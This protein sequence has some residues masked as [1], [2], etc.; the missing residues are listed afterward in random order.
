MPQ[1]TQNLKRDR[2]IH[3]L[4]TIAPFSV[5]E[6]GAQLAESGAVTDCSRSGAHVHGIVRE[7]LQPSEESKIEDS[8]REVSE[9]L[10]SNDPPSDTV[11]KVELEILSAQEIEAKCTC[12]TDEEMREQWCAHAVALLLRATD[13]GFSEPSGGFAAQEAVYRMNL[14]SPEDIA[15]VISEVS[16]VE[17]APIGSTPR[18]PNVTLVID[19]SSDRLGVQVIF[20]DQVQAPALFEDTTQAS[21]RELDNILLQILEDNGSWDDATK[22]WFINS[23]RE[24][25]MVLGL[26]RE[27]DIV[28]SASTGKKLS[29]ADGLLDASLKIEWHPTGAELVVSWLLPDGTVREKAEELI[30]SGPYWVVLRQGNSGLATIYRLSPAATRISSIFPFGS[31]LTL[32]RSQIGPLLAALTTNLVDPRRIK[33]VNPELQPDTQVVA[34]RPILEVEK[35]E[36]S[37]EHF[38]SSHQVH[39]QATL[40]FEYPTP[41]EDENLVYLP[42]REKEREHTDL[43]RSMG[44]DYV[45]DRKRYVISGDSALDL[46]HEQETR[47]PEPW[48]IAGLEQVRKAYRFAQLTVNVNLSQSKDEDGGPK[49]K[50]QIDWFDCHIS[51]A[52]NN[53]N[54]P[55]STLFKNLRHDQD[56]W[57][58]LDSGAYAKIPGGSA[59]HLKSTLGMLDPNFRLSNNIR[60]RV[61]TAQ[62]I[63]FCRLED[64][65]VQLELDTTL[66]TLA[67]RLKNFSN[68]PVL[69]LS[70]KFEGE[71]RSYQQ[72]GLSWLGFL[73]EFN[74]GGILADEMGLGKTVQTLAMLQLLADDATTKPAKGKAKTS[75]VAAEKTPSLIVAP[76]SVVMNWVYE[77]RR[78][79]PN[80][81][82]LLLHGPQRRQLLETLTQYDLVVTSYALLRIDRTELERVQFNYV[83][84]DEA[85]NIKNPQA[86]TTR[87]AKAIKARHRLAL[88]GTP[89]ENRP[90]ELWSI[91]DFVMPG[92]L[93]SMDFFK[94]FIEKPIL[95]GGPSAQVARFLNSKTRPFI[96]RRMKSEVERELPA[97]IES[98]VHVVMTDS[99]R[100]LY[101]QILEDVRPRVFDA[102]KQKGVR[103]ASVSILA[104]LLRLRQVCNHP[105]SIDALKEQPGFDSGKFELLQELVTEALESGRK[106][107]L[108]SQFKEMLAIIRRWL[109][110]ISVNY[111][112]LDGA[113]RQRQEL[114][115]QFNSNPE[116]RLF[117]ISLKAGG[118]GLNL[119]AADT[120]IIYDPWW[121]PAVEGQAVDRA[122]RIGQT[123][124]VS[125]YRL[126]TENS[127]E[128][129]IMD[130]KAKKAKLVDALVNENGLSTLNLSRA[131]LESLFSPIGEAEGITEAPASN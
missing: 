81:K 127:I 75:T 12:S 28:R 76:T 6:N 91:F 98:T 45:P 104:A 68:I 100:G 33:V 72:E 83:V 106:I 50:R 42:D 70:K 37:S 110:E 21:A 29:F 14:T 63:S 31:H 38:S 32:T 52:Q 82:V 115:D 59:Q 66:K 114:I 113:T 117:L 1:T 78:F 46:L 65:Q 25:E 103:G 118:T 87:A 48:H 24:I 90:L 130:L 2:A 108:F 39:L 94:N 102:I 119:T 16:R 84:L 79:T 8:E 105:N 93:G 20:D 17:F 86:A 35:W 11:H 18:H 101:N 129:K 40:E 9:D 74:L 69:P 30:G 7:N 49:S 23:S 47:F 22:C 64:E 92:Y 55:L 34:P 13:L 73:Q 96:L 10:A 15:S 5:I 88:T 36:R 71:L 3:F 95:D 109:Q 62:A 125:V 56:R 128:Q 80:L 19:H 41:N 53:A 60:A 58:R 26:A 85:Q 61:T 43:L 97:K 77:A 126:V 122:H 54:V 27:Y 44:F 67:K 111:L 51:L 107:L 121:N 124:T 123:K 112:Y 57:V 89:T 116:V 131:D 4:R 120:V 99:Q